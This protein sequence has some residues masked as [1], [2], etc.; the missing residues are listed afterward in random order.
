MLITLIV[1]L[2][3]VLLFYKTRR[4]ARGMLVSIDT[5]VIWLKGGQYRIFPLPGF[6]R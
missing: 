4:S 6:F 5:V 2:L 1:L 3:L